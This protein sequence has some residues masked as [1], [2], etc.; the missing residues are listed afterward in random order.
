MHM[1]NNIC[2]ILFYEKVHVRIKL[3][4]DIYYTTILQYHIILQYCNNQV[5]LSMR[6]ACFCKGGPRNGFAQQL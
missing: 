2:I 1:R 3:K 6:I 5:S 4:D